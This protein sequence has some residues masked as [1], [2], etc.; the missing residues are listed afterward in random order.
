MKPIQ[1]KEIGTNFVVY[2]IFIVILVLITTMI[3]YGCFQQVKN[4]FT[5]DAEVEIASTVLEN[6]F[7]TNLSS[8]V[9][10]CGGG[11]GKVIVVYGGGGG[12][13]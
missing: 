8:T 11:G 13:K 10:H 7:Y 6:N 5:E 2:G 12:G 3:Q 1:P 4:Y 9:V